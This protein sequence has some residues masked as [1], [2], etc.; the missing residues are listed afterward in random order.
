MTEVEPMTVGEF[1]IGMLQATH[2]KENPKRRCNCKNIIEMAKLHFDIH[3]N[4]GRE[5]EK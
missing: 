4:E 1:L 5:I 3:L 2:N